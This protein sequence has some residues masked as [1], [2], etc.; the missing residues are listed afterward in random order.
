MSVSKRLFWC[1]IIERS[2]K[3]KTHTYNWYI[4]IRLLFVTSFSLISAGDF[5]EGCNLLITSL[6]AISDTF[7]HKTFKYFFNQPLHEIC[8]NK[9]IDWP[10]FS[11]IRTESTNILENTGENPYSRI[12]HAVKTRILVHLTQWKPVFSYISCSER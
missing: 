4:Y 5:N 9:G 12:F 2:K 8:K 10:V 6:N 3:F 7:I 1:K 11:W